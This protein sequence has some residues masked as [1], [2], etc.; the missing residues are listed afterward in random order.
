VYSTVGEVGV[1]GDG[2]GHSD[3]L[4]EGGRGD[5]GAVL[6]DVDLDKH[7][8]L[9]RGGG[10]SGTYMCEQRATHMCEQGTSPSLPL[11]N[12][13]KIPLVIHQKADQCRPLTSFH[14]VQQPIDLERTR[15][16]TSQKEV[17]HP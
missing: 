13:A 9:A 11:S 4:I 15:D 14:Q 2:F 17:V 6:A 12:L 8:D 5:A 3:D 1:R 10:A 7:A 16:L